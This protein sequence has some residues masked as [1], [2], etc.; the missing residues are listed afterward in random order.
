MANISGTVS[1]IQ[2]TDLGMAKVF[3]VKAAHAGKFTVQLPVQA[4]QSVATPTQANFHWSGIE[5]LEAVHKAVK[6]VLEV[7]AKPPQSK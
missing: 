3:E 4:G 6:Q 7:E 5:G 1:I 2:L